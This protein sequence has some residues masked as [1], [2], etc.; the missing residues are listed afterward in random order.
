MNPVLKYVITLAAIPIL[1]LIF[2]VGYTWI[3]DDAIPPPEF[4][5][6]EEQVVVPAVESAAAALP[7]HEQ[8]EA[9]CYVV[10]DKPE[11]AFK[12]LR[13]KVGK[14]G[15]YKLV[16]PEVPEETKTEG[17]EAVG[18]FVADLFK[19]EDK[20]P[21]IK[22][23]LEMIHTEETVSAS[24]RLE[25]APPGKE[26]QTYGPYTSNYNLSYWNADYVGYLIQE[27]SAWGR[28]LIWLLFAGLL[29]VI[30]IPLIKKV[31]ALEKNSANAFLLIGMAMADAIM[32]F[33]LKGFSL[34]GFFGTVLFIAGL[35]MAF[36]WNALVAD[37]MENWRK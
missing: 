32:M 28:L 33:I 21:T 1:V 29:P 12:L 27:T 37:K 23:W 17:I 19:K 8:T 4:S 34:G 6:L 11:A 18:K 9:L 24:L 36:T 15:K 35:A 16:K 7:R 20:R 22:A 3:T 5:Y 26:P 2:Y 10:S 25:F 30:S 14:A 13:R 31:L